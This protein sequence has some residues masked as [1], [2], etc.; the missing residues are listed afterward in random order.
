MQYLKGVGPARAAALARLGIETVED[1][2]FHVP[3]RHEDRTRLVPLR[4]LLH[5]E[6]RTVEATVA[7]VNEFRPRRGLIVTKAALVDESGIGYAIWY[8]QSYLKQQLRRGMR[9]L[10]FGRAE[11]RG[12]EIR[13]TAPEFEAVEA[14]DEETWHTGRLVPI[15]PATE[16]L[17]QRVLRNLVRA[18][19]AA[20]AA[21][22]EE[23]LPEEIRHPRGFPPVGGAL[24]ALH[25]PDTVEAQRAARRRLAFEELLILQLGVLLRREQGRQAAKPMRYRTGPLADRFLSTLPFPLT[26]AQRRAIEE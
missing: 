24:W 10:F 26:G 9:A 3:R 23:T 16:G 15:Y 13:L 11:R 5:G 1:L 4:D 8:N 19:L 21:E 18:T 17:S 12:G 20:H 14:G 7:A 6:E 25:F 2:L 22:V